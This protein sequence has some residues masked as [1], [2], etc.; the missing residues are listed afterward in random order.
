MS[1]VT[2]NSLQP[3][4]KPPVSAGVSG[5]PP[6]EYSQEIPVRSTSPRHHAAPP[7]LPPHLLQVILNKETPLHVS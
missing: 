2:W 5:S 7:V 6:G 4:L 3:C 1:A